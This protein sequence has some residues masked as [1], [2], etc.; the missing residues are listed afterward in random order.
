M[1]PCVHYSVPLDLTH[2]HVNRKAYRNFL[3]KQFSVNYNFLLLFEEKERSPFFS[4]GGRLHYWCIFH[5]PQVGGK[6]AFIDQT[7]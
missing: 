6:I 7:G 5:E 2:G 4:K 3:D 1:L